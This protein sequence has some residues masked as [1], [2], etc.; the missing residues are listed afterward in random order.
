MQR[1][2]LFLRGTLARQWQ[3]SVSRPTSERLLS[4]TSR[5]SD[6]AF[7]ARRGSIAKHSRLPRVP[8]QIL[9]HQP[10][11]KLR[12]P[13]LPGKPGRYWRSFPC[14]PV[15]P[16]SAQSAAEY[17]LCGEGDALYL[18]PKSQIIP[19][20]AVQQAPRPVQTLCGHRTHEHCPRKSR[21]SL[22]H[23]T[24]DPSMLVFPSEPI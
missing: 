14:I 12:N 10:A 13:P 8:P 19:T 1:G 17:A 5:H 15:A 6:L 4:T 18:V 21:C 7:N 20:L 2:L 23:T 24:V 11:R 16:S 9:T 22:I 3:R